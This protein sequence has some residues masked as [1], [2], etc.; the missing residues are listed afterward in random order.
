M[1]EDGQ[2]ERGGGLA[3]PTL[4]GV[5]DSLEHKWALVALDDGQRL[6]WPRDRLPPGAKE[7]VVVDLSLREPG[8]CGALPEEGTWEG[9]IE[10]EVQVLPAQIAVRLGTQRV[11]WPTVERFAA[12][13][14]AVVQMHVDPDATDQRRRQV[15]DLIDDL[16]G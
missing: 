16:F 14:P 4:T 8:T 10:A 2:T 6:N 7:G 12:G 3:L 13:Q 15:E 5:I 11:R 9:T 1:N